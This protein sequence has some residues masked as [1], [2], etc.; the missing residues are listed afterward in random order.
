MLQNAFFKISL[1]STVLLSVVVNPLPSPMR[2]QTHL[3]N[4]RNSSTTPISQSLFDEFEELSRIVDISYCVG[5]LNTGV[6][7]PFECLSYCK[8][9][10]T[11][12][13]RQ[14]WNTGV[15]L[16]DSCGYVALSHAPA[17]PRIIVAFRGTYSI[18]N[19]IADLSLTKQEYVPYPSRDRQEKCEGCRVHSGFYE[20]WTQSEA[21][22]G[23][24]VDELVREY[25]GYKLTLVGHSLGGAI[26]ALAGL[27]FRGRGYNPIVTTFGEP[28]VGNSA[29]A[30]FL[31]KKFTTDTYRRVTHIHDPV[32]LVPLTQWNYSQHAYEYYISAPQLPYTREDIHLCEGSEDAS[33]VAG[34]NPNALQLF[35]AHR[36]Y[37][38]RMGLCVPEDS[39]LRRI[40]LWDSVAE[41]EL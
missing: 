2:E 28:K 23:D 35:W 30:G 38:H 22:I 33:C 19:A 18:A 31:N 34:G 15:T 32:P 7:R 26:A 6:E 5:S 10:P 3:T 8:N 16:Q 37:F 40:R 27:D 13:L 25:P 12:E 39:F 4:R 29:L 41:N 20:S 21:I 36:D 1:V 24:I 11:F 14:T 9:F 17:L